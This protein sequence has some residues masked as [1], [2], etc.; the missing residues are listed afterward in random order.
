MPVF[1]PSPP[2]TAKCAFPQIIKY[3]S[4]SHLFFP[5]LSFS[6]FVLD[7]NSRASLPSHQRLAMDYRMARRPGT[8]PLLWATPKSKMFCLCRTQKKTRKISG[9]NAESLLCAVFCCFQVRRSVMS[10]L[11]WPL[12]CE[13]SVL[14]WG[15]VAAYNSYPHG[16]HSIPLPPISG[17]VFLTGMFLFV[18]VYL[19]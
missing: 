6:M 3:L 19:V 7:P 1:R 16:M 5:R 18:Y 9:R 15:V 13:L 4:T 11:G 10:Y 2:N 8:W 12:F 17:I 14:V